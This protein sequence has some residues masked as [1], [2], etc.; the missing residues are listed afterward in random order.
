MLSFGVNARRLFILA[1]FVVVGVAAFGLCRTR[2][3]ARSASR[4]VAHP[5]TQNALVRKSASTIADPP[6]SMEP[7]V[8]LWRDPGYFS[9][10]KPEVVVAI[11][12]DGLVV[13]EVDGLLRMGR[14]EPGRVSIL[15]DE[16]ENS[17]F[18]APTLYSG[19]T[20]VDVSYRRVCAWKRG[21]RH[22]L[23]YDG[24]ADFRDLGPQASPSRK[25][26]DDFVVMWTRVEKALASVQPP[27]LV[28]YE[29]DR[30][31]RFPSLR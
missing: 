1:C 13:R 21:E 30:A 2:S 3:R 12:A 24:S 6:E 4:P 22:T 25:Q 15:L 16:L 5:S 17:G 28:D 8:S 11:W 9:N 19:L 31:L 20:H 14:V 10:Q 7:V 23:D 26:C 27:T 18:F 29:T